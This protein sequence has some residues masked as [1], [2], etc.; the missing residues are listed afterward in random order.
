MRRTLHTMLIAVVTFLAVP[1][2]H[3]G[4]YNVYVHGRSWGNWSAETVNAAGWTNVTLAFDGNARLNGNETNVT[5]RNAIYAYCSNGNLCHVVCYS[6]GCLRT[7][8]AIDDLRAMG[9]TLPGLL[10]S[11]GAASAA[12]G[13]KLASIAT[14]GFTGF[15]AKLFG[16]QEKIDFDLTTSAA[17][18]TWGYVQDAFPPTA[19]YHMGGNAN[20]CKKILF[21]KICGNKYVDAGVADGLVGLDSSSGSS[22][23]GY[24]Y[25]GCN[26]AKYPGRYWE[27]GRPCGGE[28]KD[29]FGM[30][31][32][33]MSVIGPQI[34]G[35]GANYGFSWGDLT[36]DPDCNDANG[37]C[38][39]A[40]S[41]TQ[42]DYSKTPALQYV[43]PDVSAKA[44][45]TTFNTGGATCSGKCGGYSGAGC[46][47]DS[48]CVSYGDCCGDY[49]AAQCNIVNAQ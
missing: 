12:G 43:A 27:P 4:Y 7:L 35:T 38:D 16:Q 46:W 47:C 18:S 3:A 1:R 44:S 40:F 2:A 15:L 25:D 32:A 20:I 31:G 34:G 49:Y 13:T 28:P 11:E 8:K 33:T 24:I 36:G 37:E 41:V 48:Y 19:L 26:V 10:W 9:Y 6:A 14:K 23:N 39:N 29:H 5:V 30:P 21:F 42:A 17:R 22:T 45:N